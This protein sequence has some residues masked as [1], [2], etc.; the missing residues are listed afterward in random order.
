MRSSDGLVTLDQVVS[1]NDLGVILDPNLKFRGNISSWVNKANRLLGIIRRSFSHL[2]ANMFKL[3]YKA[4]VRSHIEYAAAVW[5]PRYISD[6]KILV[7]VQHRTTRQ[8]P[9]IKAL[10]YQERPKILVTNTKILEVQGR[11]HRSI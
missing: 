7:F 9:E 8:L 10:S 6:I 2:N 3:L 11:C 1:E 5:S 4:L